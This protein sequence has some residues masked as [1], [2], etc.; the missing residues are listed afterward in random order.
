MPFHDQV[1][2]FSEITGHTDLESVNVSAI[3]WQLGKKS[4][5]M[6][7]GRNSREGGYKKEEQGE[8]YW[9]VLLLTLIN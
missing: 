5:E 8:N 2:S 1:H 9:Q 3:I 6:G 4:R 7:K